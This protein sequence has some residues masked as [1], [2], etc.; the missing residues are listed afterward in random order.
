VADPVT[1]A[2]FD[3]GRRVGEAVCVRTRHYG[4]FLR[5]LGDTIVMMPPPTFSDAELE[6]MVDAAYAAALDV[7]G[8]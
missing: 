8:G 6:R 2:P 1:R 4:V 3:A 7:L 5:P